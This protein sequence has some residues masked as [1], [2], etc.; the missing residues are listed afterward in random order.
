MSQNGGSIQARPSQFGALRAAGF[1]TAITLF[2]LVFRPFDLSIDS[3]ADVLV[4]SGIAP[5]SFVVMYAIHRVPISIGRVRAVVGALFLVAA[6]SAYLVFWSRSG[7]SVTIVVEVTL[8][9]GLAMVM[10]GMWNRERT[11]YEALDNKAGD[12]P[13]ERISIVLRGENDRDI[14]H[15]APEELTY[16]SADGNYVDVHYLKNGEPAVALLRSSLSGLVGQ[17]QQITLTQCHRS[18]FVNL[19]AIHRIVSKRGRHEIEFDHGDRVP[20][21]RTY[22]DSVYRAVTN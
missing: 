8:V 21:S 3:L 9:A 20:I 18:Y 19:A 12:L 4:V 6:N 14:L 7:F 16:L 22:K 10:I 1:A 5:L 11:R 15:L 2:L 17:L 13:L